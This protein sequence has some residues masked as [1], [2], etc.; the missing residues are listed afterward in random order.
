M[1]SDLSF[2]VISNLYWIN[3]FLTSQSHISKFFI[4]SKFSTQI[5]DSKPFTEELVNDYLSPI[6]W[7]SPQTSLIP[8]SYTTIQRTKN[9]QNKTKLRLKTHALILIWCVESH[10]HI[11]SHWQ[12]MV[13]DIE[14]KDTSHKTNMWN[15]LKK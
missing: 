4:P 5:W 1:A 2:K 12:L 7:T 3:T 6:S 14:S 8:L 11:V 9:Q 10:Q 13:M 15:K